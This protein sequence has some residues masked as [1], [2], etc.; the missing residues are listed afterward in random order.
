LI[1]ADDSGSEANV[2]LKVKLVQGRAYIIRVR[3]NFVS[4]AAGVGLLI[5]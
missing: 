2:N 4:G 1:S 5:Y 3:V